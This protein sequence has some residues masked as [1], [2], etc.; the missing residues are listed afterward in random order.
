MIN[1]H[2]VA[3]ILLLA[4]LLLNNASAQDSSY[5]PERTAL[6]LVDPFN[7]FLSEGGRLYQ[8]S[9]ETLDANNAIQHMVEVTNAARQAGMRIVYV[10][11]HHYQEGDYSGWKFLSPTQRGAASGMVFQANTWNIEYYPGLDKQAGDLEARQH[12][13]S[14]GFAN[15]D[16]D[17]LLKLHGIDH[18][19]LAGMRANT[20][21]ES[22]GRYAVEL[23]YHTTLIKD[24]IGAFSMRE[25]EA[26]AE[27]NFPAFAHAVM[28]TED[29]VKAIE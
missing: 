1:K 17:F 10:P 2:I 4:G 9:K 26:A 25:V 15:T 27:I 29:F 21:I 18:V 11:H 7:E 13:S 20:C 22:T 12:W 19:V 6:L 14:S 23:G 3:G 5:D 24:A 16:L 28:T 8:L